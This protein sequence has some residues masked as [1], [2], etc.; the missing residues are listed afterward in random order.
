MLS[1]DDSNDLD[2]D[3]AVTVSKESMAVSYKR[4]LN[5]KLRM[6]GEPYLGYSRSKRNQ[7]L[8]NVNRVGKN[9]RPACN[10]DVCRKSQKRKCNEIAEVNRL[11]IF[12]HFWKNLNWDEKKTYVTSL[13]IT[14]PVKQRTVESSRR[15]STMSYNLKVKDAYLCVCKTMFLNTLGLG[16]KQVLTWCLTAK[17]TELNNYET[18][19]EKNIRSTMRITPEKIKRKFVSEFLEKLPKLPSHY[20]RKSTSRLYFEPY[21]KSISQLYNMYG[22]MCNEE[23]KQPVS[24]K[25]FNEIYNKTNFSVYHPKKDQCDICCSYQ[26][27]NI[28]ED[29]WNEHIKDKDRSREE[30]NRDKE[31]AKLNEIIVFTMDLQAVKICPNLKASALY[32]KCKL[33][34]HNFT[35]YNLSS[36]ECTCYWWDETQSDL[37]ASSFVSC[38]IDQITEYNLKYPLKNIILWSDGCCYQNRNCVLSNALLEFAINNTISIEQKYLTKGHTQMECDSVH[39]TI[40]NKLRNTDIYLPS[41]YMRITKS[42]RTKPFPY[43]VKYCDVNFFKKYELDSYRFDTIRPGKKAG[44]PTVA[45]I[46][47]LRYNCDGSIEFKLN[48][49]DDYLDLNSVQKQRKK[50]SKTLFPTIY[51]PLHTSDLKIQKTKWEHLQQLKSVLPK[52]CHE[53]YNKIKY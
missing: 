53:F 43:N 51:G 32:Y 16:E 48:F 15:N 46:K 8:Q 12:N 47:A 20:C 39:S 38:I 24:R 18:N 9:I 35:M 30:K 40:E 2:M 42:A 27:K 44:D 1:A 3:Y 25:I 33:C 50:T 28:G 17:D 41:D 19:K 7:I 11:G 34:V 6:T 22:I 26:T 10:S 14:T 13:I 37:S 45:N 29:E 36:H 49:D 5:Q 31:K 4:K 52:D 23:N 21:I